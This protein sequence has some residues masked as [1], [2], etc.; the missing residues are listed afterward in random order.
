MLIQ[1][2]SYYY[3]STQTSFSQFTLVLLIKNVFD[4]LS[5][6]TQAYP[7]SLVTVRSSI[8]FFVTFF[9]SMIS[10]NMEYLFVQVV[11]VKATGIIVP[12]Y[13]LLRIT[14][15]ISNSI[16]H[17]DHLVITVAS[18]Q[19]IH[20]CKFLLNIHLSEFPF[21]ISTRMN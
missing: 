3:Y 7:F 18:T 14:S 9:M 12:I 15:M 17:Q 20:R 16:N 8:H 11:I 1:L 13:I 6:G 5:G 10:V 4:I 19:P 2:Q 21:Q